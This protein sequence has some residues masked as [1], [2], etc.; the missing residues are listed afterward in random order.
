M[1]SSVTKN[2]YDQIAIPFI[3]NLLHNYFAQPIRNYLEILHWDF[4]VHKPIR[5]TTYMYYL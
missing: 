5:P 3:T 1:Y 2:P 4:L